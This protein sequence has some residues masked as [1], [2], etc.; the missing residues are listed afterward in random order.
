MS[1][2]CVASTPR[3]SAFIRGQRRWSVAVISRYCPSSKITAAPSE[4]RR[5]GVP[6]NSST[7]RSSGVTRGCASRFIPRG[8]P[9]EVRF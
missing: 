5:D 6:T 8:G 3:V 7:F 9:T 2:S 4:G 1:S